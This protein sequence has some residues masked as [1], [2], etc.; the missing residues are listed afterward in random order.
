MDMVDA[1]EEVILLSISQPGHF[2]KPQSVTPAILS[3][4]QTLVA[5]RQR[6]FKQR[7]RNGTLQCAL[8]DDL[9]SMAHLSP[10]SQSNELEQK[11]AET[12][13][14]I[15]TERKILEGAQLIRQAT[16]NQDVLK[17]NDAKIKETERTLAYFE[18]TLRELQA[19]AQQAQQNEGRIGGPS[20]P[21]VSLES[22]TS[23]AVTNHSSTQGSSQGQ[24]SRE[25]TV[26]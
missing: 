9:L 10:L 23:R 4:S 7:D 18:D 25:G 5:A 14:H 20:T 21:Q 22:T 11:I 17:R 26:P 13:K 16:T 15:Q 8:V 19:R 2:R 1:V 24:K 3:F 6:Q 12:W